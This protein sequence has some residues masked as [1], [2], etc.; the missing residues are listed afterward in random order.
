MLDQISPVYVSMVFPD[1]KDMPLFGLLDPDPVPDP[2]SD[3]DPDPDPNPDPD[4]VT[5]PVPDH[6][7]DHDPDPDPD[8]D[9]DRVE[10][11][12]VPVLKI[13]SGKFVDFED[14]G[15]PNPK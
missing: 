11:R 10:S 13:N 2:D 9:P 4:P 5:D 3:P 1:R 7:P 6:D 14:V 8:P 12:Q 15:T